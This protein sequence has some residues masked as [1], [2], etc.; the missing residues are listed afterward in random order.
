[1][2]VRTTLSLSG[3]FLLCETDMVEV[4]CYLTEGAAFK[5]PSVCE[6]SFN[7]C[8]EKRNGIIK[9]VT[10]WSRVSL[11]HTD[12]IQQSHCGYIS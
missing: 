7:Q 4:D 1:M 12:T 5:M 8:C 10:D 9:K 6:N 11:E 2:G 3:C